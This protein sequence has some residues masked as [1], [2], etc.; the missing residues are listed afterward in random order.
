MK[1]GRFSPL[2]Q[3]GAEGMIESLL[4][5]ALVLPLV[6]VLPGGDHGRVEDTLSTLRMLRKSPFVSL[7]CALSPL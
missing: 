5:G 6:A 3:V 1:G 2:L 7:M 4:C